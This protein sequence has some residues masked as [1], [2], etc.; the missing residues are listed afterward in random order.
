MSNF[1]EMEYKAIETEELIELAS[2][3][4]SLDFFRK[5]YHS[6]RQPMTRRMRAAEFALQFE[7]PKLGAI[8][9]AS[10]NG[11]DFASLLEKAILR[12][13][14]EREVKQIEARAEPTD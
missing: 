2:H 4:T 7:H 10:M 6:V 13:N 5:I 8:A 3:E 1:P 14:E 9:T 12:S 11:Q